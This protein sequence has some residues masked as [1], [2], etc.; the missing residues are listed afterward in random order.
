M[1]AF[2]DRR[3]VAVATTLALSG[4][5]LGSV[6]RLV[7]NSTFAVF[8]VLIISGVAVS[9]VTWRNAQAAGSVGQLLH[10]TDAGR[11]SRF[12]PSDRTRQ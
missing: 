5:W 11:S 8:A 9:F 4:L 10:E 12:A 7:S 2:S 3:T 6:P 1:V